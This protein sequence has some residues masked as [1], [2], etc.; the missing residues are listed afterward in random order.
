MTRRLQTF[1]AN[2]GIRIFSIQAGK[3][4]Q[5]AYASAGLGGPQVSVSSTLFQGLQVVYVGVDVFVI[6]YACC[7]LP[8]AA[9]IESWISEVLIKCPPELS[10]PLR[11]DQC[12]PSGPFPEILFFAP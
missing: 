9:D 3:P 2:P 8:V 11:R 7:C 10:R 6:L 5:K 4:Q 12:R 1:V